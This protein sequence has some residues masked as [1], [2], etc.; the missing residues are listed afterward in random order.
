M[1]RNPLLNW[2]SD[3]GRYTVLI[4]ERAYVDMVKLAIQNSP[5]KIG[6]SLI[7]SY[8][9]GGHVATILDLAPISPDSKGTPDSF[10]RGVDGLS[11]HFKEVF[12]KSE[13]QH[14]YVGDWHSRPGGDALPSSM[15][16]STQFDIAKDEDAN[17]PE[18]ILV[19][20]GGEPPNKTHIGVYVYSREH[21]RID[22]HP[23]SWEQQQ[24][25]LIEPL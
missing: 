18:V 11:E 2:R 17:C 5:N 9:D 4:S 15:D 12:D 16:D 19:I 24:C 6:S 8:S 10:Y 13:G 23:I 21:G 3:C 25:C 7:G 22:L 1:T 14:F 20:V